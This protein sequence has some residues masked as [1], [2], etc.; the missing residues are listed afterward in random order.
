MLTFHD[1][2][3]TYWRVYLDQREALKDAGLDPELPA[4]KP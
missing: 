3:V 2:K 1:G 4:A